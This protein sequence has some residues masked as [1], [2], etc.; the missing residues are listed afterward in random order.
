MYWALT[1]KNVPTL[2]PKKN[3][4]GITIEVTSSFKSPHELYPKIPKVLSDVVMECVKEKPAERPSNML[5]VTG[6]L[7]ELIRE[8]FGSKITSNAATKHTTL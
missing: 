5:E 4:F 2:I 1:G 3:E 7:D 8:I 6:R